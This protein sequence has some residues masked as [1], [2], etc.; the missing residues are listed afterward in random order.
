MAQTSYAAC[1]L[2]CYGCAQACDQCAQAC[3]DEEDIKIMAKCIRHDIDCAEA[4]RFAA[5]LLARHSGFAVEACEL[6]ASV[7]DA[8]AAVCGQHDADHCKVCAAAC[9]VCADACRSMTVGG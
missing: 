2:A 7:C 9:I 6:C 4:C 3:L 5:A 8:C 1:I